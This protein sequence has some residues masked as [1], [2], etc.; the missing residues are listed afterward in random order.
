MNYITTIG[1]F[2]NFGQVFNSLVSNYNIKFVVFEQNKENIEILNYCKE[3]DIEYFSVKSIQEIK[4]VLI[5]Y[6][7]IDLFI[8][9]SFGL[10]FD[11]ELINYPKYNTINFHPG[12]LPKY[13]G[14]HPLPQAIVNRDR[15][16]GITSHIMN[17]EIDKGRILGMKKI[18]IDY[19]LSYKE[20][21][22]ILLSHMKDIVYQTFENYFN[23]K[24]IIS[25]EE[26]NYYRPLNRDILKKIFSAKKLKE[27]RFDSCD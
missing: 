25:S 18:P 5:P 20:N 3:N 4:N 1:F 22:K 26:E 21:E 2:G 7:N 23:N 9:A 19:E 11:K 17:L 16:M 6:K 10:I 12:V 27:L 13:R 8:V 15:Y 24:Y 14:R